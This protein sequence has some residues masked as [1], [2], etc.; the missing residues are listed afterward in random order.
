MS[1]SYN[2]MLAVEAAE[3]G[4]T[5]IA[6]SVPG[7]KPLTDRFLRG[8]DV[9]ALRRRRASGSPA[10]GSVVRPADRR[11]LTDHSDLT[12]SSGSSGYRR[13]HDRGIPRLYSNETLQKHV[14]SRYDVESGGPNAVRDEAD[15]ADGILVRVDFN[16]REEQRPQ[17]TAHS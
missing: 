16:V 11:Q 1:W 8:K 17:M 13:H 14:Q 10:G 6:L 9:D 5:L 12:G 2:P 7:L 3:I 4:A 15:G